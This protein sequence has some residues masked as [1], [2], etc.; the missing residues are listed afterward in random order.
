MMCYGTFL[1]VKLTYVESAR[2][3][4]IR[5]ILSETR[6]LWPCRYRLN[7]AASWRRV[8]LWSATRLH[9]VTTQKIIIKID[10][11]VS[12]CVRACIRNMHIRIH[13][14]ILAGARIRSAH[15]HTCAHTSVDSRKHVHMCACN[16]TCLHICMNTCIY[17][18]IFIDTKNCIRPS[19]Y[20]KPPTNSSLWWNVSTINRMFNYNVRVI[21]LIYSYG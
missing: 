11:F 3:F 10:R 12:V 2:I 18:Y 4:S 19:C 14:R 21:N 6:F 7:S 1:C 13:A 20:M 9:G 16:H 17:A 8:D 15:T 5:L